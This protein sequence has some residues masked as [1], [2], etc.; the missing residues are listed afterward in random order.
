MRHKKNLIFPGDYCQIMASGSLIIPYQWHSIRQGKL[1][2]L[3]TILDASS[4]GSGAALP[5]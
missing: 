4:S 5:K 3:S 2:S 1:L